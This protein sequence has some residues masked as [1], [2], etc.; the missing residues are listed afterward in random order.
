MALHEAQRC[1]S[2]CASHRQIEQLPN[3]NRVRAPTDQTLAFGYRKIRLPEFFER[4]D[5]VNRCVGTS[6]REC[7][8]FG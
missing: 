8:Q 1:T 4:C 6:L 7:L 2:F 5:V 3:E